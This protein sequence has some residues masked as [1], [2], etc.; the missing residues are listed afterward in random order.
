MPSYTTPSKLVEYYFDAALS[1]EQNERLLS[2]LVYSGRIR[3]ER[4]PGKPLTVQELKAWVARRG[5]P[6]GYL[7]WLGICVE[8]AIKE[9]GRP[10]PV[11]VKP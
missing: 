9:L 2:R 11:L 1:I 8:D 7:P 3:L 4:A 6:P 5:H 10:R